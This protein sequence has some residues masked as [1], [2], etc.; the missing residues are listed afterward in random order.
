MAISFRYQAVLF[1]TAF[2]CLTPT[3]W[4][5]TKASEGP[6]DLIEKAQ[7]LIIQKERSAAIQLLVGAIRRESPKSSAS[8]EMKTALA[9]MTTIF[10]SDKTQQTYELA[11]TFRRTDL[12]QAQQRINEAL[13]QEPQNSL[14]IVENARIQ[15]LR[16]D[17]AAAQEG[18]KKAKDRNPYD[19]L[20]LL[21][22]AQTAIC[23]GDIPQYTSIRSSADTSK[24]IYSREWAALEVERAL[25]EKAESR[26]RESIENLVTMDPGH[27]EISFWRFQLEKSPEKKKSPALKYVHGCKSMPLSVARRYLHEVSVCR[28]VSEIE[29]FLGSRGETLPSR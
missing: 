21:G 29:D 20:I 6:R 15:S 16:G 19:E 18:L 4:S 13:R 5:Q 9:G 1:G 7:N 12:A 3:A 26:A 28:R 27:P 23:L 17:C 14:L 25:L 24:G 22:L 2:F 11:L 10:F 8:K